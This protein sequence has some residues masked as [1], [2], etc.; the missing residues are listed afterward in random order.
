[1]NARELA[2]VLIDKVGDANL[3]KKITVYVDRLILRLQSQPALMSSLADVTVYKPGIEDTTNDTV[4]DGKFNEDEQQSDLPQPEVPEGGVILQLSFRRLPHEVIA[5]LLRL[6][7]APRAPKL[8][9]FIK[10]GQARTGI[11][12]ELLPDDFPGDEYDYAN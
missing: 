7:A 6:I 12:I 11:Q 2:E 3:D 10:G 9:R 1:M 5:P 8:F 4:E